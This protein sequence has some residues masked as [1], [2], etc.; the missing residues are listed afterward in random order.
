MFY[1]D[2]D[3]VKFCNCKTSIFNLRGGTNHIDIGYL[4]YTLLNVNVHIHRGSAH[5]LAFGG[6]TSVHVG[7]TWLLENVRNTRAYCKCFLCCFSSVLRCVSFFVCTYFFGKHA[8]TRR[9]THSNTL[10]KHLQHI[11]TH[12]T[13]SLLRSS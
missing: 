8:R 12:S 11:T 4:L 9:K 2:S 13:F 1:S 6:R 10:A 7:L 5:L 3:S